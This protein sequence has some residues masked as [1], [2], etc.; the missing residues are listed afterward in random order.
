[1]FIT[2]YYKYMQNRDL[3]KLLT[4]QLRYETMEAVDSSEI[5]SRIDHV[6]L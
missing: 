3:D 4:H 2:L 1:M 6:R 5:Q